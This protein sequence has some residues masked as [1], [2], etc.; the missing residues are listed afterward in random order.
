MPRWVR[1]LVPPLFGGLLGGAITFVVLS[2][3][4]ITYLGGLHK[5]QTLLIGIL[6]IVASLI[7]LFGVHMQSLNVKRIEENRLKRDAFAFATLF[8][9]R[10]KNFNRKSL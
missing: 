6:A 9:C 3:A 1:S 4:T 2:I 8:S 5:F 7:A 10:Q